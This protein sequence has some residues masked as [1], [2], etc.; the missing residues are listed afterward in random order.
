[1]SHWRIFVPVLAP[2]STFETSPP[3]PAGGSG[4]RDGG[5]ALARVGVPL[6]DELLGLGDERRAVGDALLDAD[7]DE[8]LAGEA[9][10]VLD[11]QVVGED[12]GVGRGDLGGAEGLGPRGSLRLDEH[13]VARGLG[14]VLETLG[15]HVGVGDAGGARGDADE[16]ERALGGRGCGCGRSGAVGVRAGRGSNGLVELDLGADD[17][18][19][20]G[21][22]R[23]GGERR[24][25]VLLHEGTGELGQ[26]LHVRVAATLGGRDEEDQGGR[27]VLGAP[28]DAVG[29]PEDERG[30]GDGGAAGVRDADAAGQAGRHRLL[31]LAHVGEE[32]VEVGAAPARRRVA[33]RASGS[34][35]GGRHR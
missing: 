17:A 24:L 16:V 15:S 34:P 35:R 25:E 1:M 12:H 8:G 26:H 29:A 30:L 27:A 9:A 33:R 31:A 23:R 32:G 10:G 19:D 22:R 11:G 13:R 6:G 14:G 4:S 18:D 20:L 21:L 7:V 28:V 2:S 5:R 3:V